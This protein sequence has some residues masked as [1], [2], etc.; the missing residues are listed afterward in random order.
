MST[1]LHGV[2]EHVSGYGLHI[3]LYGAYWALAVASDDLQPASLTA[4]EVQQRLDQ[5]AIGDL[6][7]YND[8]VH[9]A[10]FALPTFYRRLMQVEE[11]AHS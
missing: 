2:F 4:H 1:A 6:Q 5:R 7:Y 3:P 11:T 8:E 9:G 10:L